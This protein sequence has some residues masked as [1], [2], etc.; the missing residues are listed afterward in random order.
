MSAR[1]YVGTL[2]GH[3]TALPRAGFRTLHGIYTSAR[4]TGPRSYQLR[5]LRSA[6]S[7]LSQLLL[8]TL[9]PVETALLH[10][11]TSLLN[12]VHQHHPAPL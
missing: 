8:A 3:I 7:L 5:R 11:H 1:N 9:I 2:S 12:T 10:G 6:E 4:Q